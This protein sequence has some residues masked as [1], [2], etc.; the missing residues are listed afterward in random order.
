VNSED[1]WVLTCNEDIVDA[2]T[3][4]KEDLLR[5]HLYINSLPKDLP[6]ALFLMYYEYLI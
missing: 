6:D 4:S 2:E 3:V 5:F 1:L